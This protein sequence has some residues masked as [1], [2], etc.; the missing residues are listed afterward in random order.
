VIYNALARA[1]THY[2]ALF[3]NSSVEILTLISRDLRQRPAVVQP[4]AVEWRAP[5]AVPAE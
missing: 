2:S 3:A 5:A 4:G 1:I